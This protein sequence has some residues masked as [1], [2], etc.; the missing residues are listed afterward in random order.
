MLA[1]V[2][3]TLATRDVVVGSTWTSSMGTPSSCAAAA[4]ILAYT[5]WPISTAPVVTD[6]VPSA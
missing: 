2:G 6:T 1:A 3:E 4:W 5:P